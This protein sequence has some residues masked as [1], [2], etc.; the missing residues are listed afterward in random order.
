MK[1]GSGKVRFDGLN[2][3]Q[4]FVRDQRGA[5]AMQFA[6][7]VIPLV[8]CVGLAVDSA[9]SAGPGANILPIEQA[10]RPTAS[11][12]EAATFSPAS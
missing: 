12:A 10:D 9:V 8:L 6:L 4:R 11:V 7:M 1:I 5:F 3:L 2:R